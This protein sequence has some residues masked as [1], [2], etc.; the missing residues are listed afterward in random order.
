MSDRPL[1]DGGKPG[2]GGPFWRGIPLCAIGGR[3][4]AIPSAN[5]NNVRVKRMYLQWQTGG[6]W[7]IHTHVL[8][9]WHSLQY[10]TAYSYTVRWFHLI[11]LIYCLALFSFII[12]QFN[13]YSSYWSTLYKHES[14]SETWGLNLLLALGILSWSKWFGF[15]PLACGS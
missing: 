12:I 9:T 14:Q 1:W 8:S 11:S 10:T 5:I 2:R 3:F 6:Q 4:L 13:L 7:F 15:T